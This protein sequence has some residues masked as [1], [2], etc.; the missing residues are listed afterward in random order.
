MRILFVNKFAF[1]RGGQERVVFDEIEG[2]RARGH[3]VELFS[4]SH[5]ENLEWTYARDFVPYREIG[6]QSRPPVASVRDMFWNREAARSLTKVLQHFNPDVAHFHGIH[7]HLTPSVLSATHAMGVRTVM[8]LHD[9][10]PICA[11]NVL[12]CGG[13]SVCSPRACG[14]LNIAAIRNRCVQGSTARSAF[15]AAELAW[16]RATRSYERHLDALVSPSRFLRDQVSGAGFSVDR[17]EVIPNAVRA[18]P[19]PLPSDGASG[20]LFAGRLSPEKGLSELLSAAQDAQV[21]LVVAGDGPLRSVVEKLPFVEYVGML[22]PASLDEVRRRT[23]G[24]VVPSIWFENAPMSILESM[25]C[26]RPVIATA[27]GG[28]PEIV[29]DGVDGILVRVGD[30]EGLAASMRRLVHSPDERRRMGK[31]A[32]KRAVSEFGMT[33]H[34]ERLE[35]VYAGESQPPT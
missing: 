28:I 20:L 1:N 22:T 19:G 23:L 16:Q 25:A 21:R 35:T 27:I 29:R 3:E 33:R 34:C 26:G 11:G 5:P 6:P 32:Y 15:A 13:R 24:A 12:L 9:Y 14:Q 2:L 17:F 31:E 4:T 10:W 8:T 7:R 18:A 30:Q